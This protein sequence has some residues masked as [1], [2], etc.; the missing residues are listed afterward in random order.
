MRTRST[1]ASGSRAWP[2]VFSVLALACGSKH[3]ESPRENE[4]LPVSCLELS[5]LLAR[6]FQSPEVGRRA[7]SGF[8]VVKAGDLAAKTRLDAECSRNLT[9]V[10]KDC[11]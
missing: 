10:R 3:K 6:C 9:D 2:I 1:R 8:P 11:R 7:Q 4:P 5:A